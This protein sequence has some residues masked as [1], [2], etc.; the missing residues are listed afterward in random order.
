MTK[1]LTQDVFKGAPEWVRSAA[2]DKD[3]DAYWY[4][5]EKSMLYA[6]RFFHQ[7]SYR[8][9]LGENLARQCYC[10]GGGYDTTDWQNSA[11]DRE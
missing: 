6:N 2:V 1:T 4:S 5:M 10:F 7:F 9:T 8:Q 11:I 3:G